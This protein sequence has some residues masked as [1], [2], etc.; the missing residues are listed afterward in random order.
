MNSSN[1]THILYVGSYT[2]IVAGD[3]G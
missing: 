2:E 1:Q 3:F